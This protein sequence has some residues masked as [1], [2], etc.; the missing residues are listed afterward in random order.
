MTEPAPR[1]LL[2][3]FQLHMDTAQSII[4]AFTR[5]FIEDHVSEDR[6]FSFINFMPLLLFLYSRFHVHKQQSCTSHTTYLFDW[7]GSHRYCHR[8]KQLHSRLLKG[9]IMWG[10]FLSCILWLINLKRR[11]ITALWMQLYT[12]YT[13]YKHHFNTNKQT[14][15]IVVCSLMVAIR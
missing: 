11:C 4:N 6:S 1:A 2:Y 15:F 8:G 9:I 14:P 5:E 10:C 3:L 13:L 12:L 7:G